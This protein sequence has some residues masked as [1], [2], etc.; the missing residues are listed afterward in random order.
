MKVLLVL[1]LTLSCGKKS[2]VTKLPPHF[3]SEETTSTEEAETNFRSIIRS[4][5][6]AL[7]KL[8]DSAG[9]FQMKEMITDIAVA[10]TGL[11]GLSAL[12]AN[13]GVEIRWVKQNLSD[14]TPPEKAEIIFEE[15]TTTEDAT[16]AV[17][18][19]VAASGKIKTTTKLRA[20]IHQSLEQIRQLVDEAGEQSRGNWEFK[21]VRFDLN[22]SVNG[23]VFFFAKAGPNLRMRM[24]WNHHKGNKSNSGAAQFIRKTMNVLNAVNSEL[25]LPGFKTRQLAL[26]VGTTYKGEYGVWKYATGFMCFLLFVPTN[27]K[28]DFPHTPGAFLL[29]GFD[30][31]GP[32]TL[33]SEK[34]VSGLRK[35]LKTAAFFADASRGTRGI[36]SVKEIKTVNDISYTGLFGLADFTTRGSMEIDFKRI[37]Q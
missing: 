10:R 22:F 17:L 32:A 14:L 34:F 23:E 11:L 25:N 28:S 6:K 37:T 8:N 16:N 3:V 18:K 9:G 27:A 5:E 4:Q 29:G 35:S 2:P 13:S 26:G 1:L 24:E 15:E 33:S 12:K 36:W 30:E 19:L 31:K 20:R 21:G 7:T